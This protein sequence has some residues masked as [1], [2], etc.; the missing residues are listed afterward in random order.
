MKFGVLI[1]IHIII[2]YIAQLKAFIA[3][4]SILRAYIV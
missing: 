4:L 1:F 2:F 3:Y